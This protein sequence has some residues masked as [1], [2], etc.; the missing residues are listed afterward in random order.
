M[1]IS[2]K[3]SASAGTPEGSECLGVA[4]KYFRWA[5]FCALFSA[6]YENFS[7]GV[8]SRSMIF[9]FVIPLAASALFLLIFLIRPSKRPSPWPRS[10]FGSGVAALTVGSCWRGVI[11]IYGIT[12]G[13]TKVYFAVGAVLVLAAAIL[14]VKELAA[15]KKTV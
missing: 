12:S 10:L 7:H 15:G 1:S 2:A 9:M 13:F 11:H 14:Y 6:I 8:Y 4:R 3:L 5:V